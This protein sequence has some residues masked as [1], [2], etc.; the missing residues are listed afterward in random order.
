VLGEELRDLDVVP[1]L[2]A[3]EVVLHQDDRLVRRAANPVEFPVRSPLLDRGDFDLRFL[4]PGKMD[5][6]LPEEQFG[7]GG[8]RC[9]CH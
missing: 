4:E 5:P 1:V 8:S 7:L 9:R 6:G 2:F 3:F